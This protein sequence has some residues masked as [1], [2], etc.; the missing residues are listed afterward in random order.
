MR[1]TTDTFACKCPAR[2]TAACDHRTKA[3]VL[4]AAALRFS[5][6]KSL[7]NTSTKSQKDFVQIWLLR[8]RTN[9]KKT[10]FSA[11]CVDADRH[12]HNLS[13]GTATSGKTKCRHCYS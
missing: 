4:M 6:E 11:L 3:T 8:R 9:V 7:T 5:R 2:L 10:Q 12:C 13:N 1:S